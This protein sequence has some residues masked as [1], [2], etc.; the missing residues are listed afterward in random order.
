MLPR[1]VHFEMLIHIAVAKQ[2]LIMKVGLF[3]V[4]VGVVAVKILV[5]FFNIL[6]I[7]IFFENV[8][9]LL[10]FYLD[11]RPKLCFHLVFVD[12][13]HLLFRPEVLVI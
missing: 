3:L 4:E 2:Q 11:I 13:P 1:L 5:K 10:L 7:I 6:L 12:T 8:I 9:S